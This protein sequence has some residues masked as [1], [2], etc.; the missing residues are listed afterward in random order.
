MRVSGR[1]RSLCLAFEGINTC[2]ERQRREVSI[3]LP[4]VV[5]Q[6]VRNSLD[7]LYL[8][9]LQLHLLAD[10]LRS[11]LPLRPLQDDTSLKF[12]LENRTS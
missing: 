2:L 6:L 1:L 3:S 12:T 9:T 4:L 5:K 11:I 7:V 10:C 8:T